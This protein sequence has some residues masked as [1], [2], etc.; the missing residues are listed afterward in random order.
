MQ[1]LTCP[2]CAG[3]FVSSEESAGRVV[4][5]PHCHAQIQD[6][7]FASS[8][9]P[10]E[11]S[12]E[13]GAPT[14]DPPVTLPLPSPSEEVGKTPQW[15]NIPEHD[16]LKFL[17]KGGMGIVLQA[18]HRV[19]DRLVAVKMP[20]AGDWMD[21][22]DRERFLREARAT[23]KLRHPNI[24]PVFEVGET[25][26]RPYITMAY[27]EGESL[28]QWAR[29][30]K[31]N[32]R[33]AAEMLA[34]L[35]RAVEFAHQQGIVHRDIKPQNVLVDR[36]SGQPMLMD[37]GLA[38]EM[39]LA[40][41]ELT[42]SGQV[43]GTPAYMAPEQAAGRLRDV[44]PRSDVYALGAVLYHLLCGRPP[45]L[46][47]GG[48]VLRQL[49]TDVPPA[50]RKLAP[51]TN[52]DLETICLT[53][54]ARE[55]LRRY[56]SAS[57]LAA[58]LQRFVIGEAI[59]AHREGLPR[60]ISRMVRRRPVV[61]ALTTLLMVTIA[62]FTYSA[63]VT[64][65]IA[66]LR[67]TIRNRVD[68]NDWTPSHFNQTESDID[69][70]ATM[71]PEQA[72]LDRE[73]FHQ[74]FAESLQAAIQQQRVP[75]EESTR[76]E[77]GIAAL[78][79]RD[80]SRAADLTE[81]LAARL[82]DW[83]LAF[84]LRPPF[85]NLGAIFDQEKVHIDGD[86]LRTT[87]GTVPTR[88]A[89]AGDASVEVEFQGDD[90]PTVPF[91]ILVD[92]DSRTKG[93][94]R[95][96]EFVVGPS[97]HA[98]EHKK[99][100]ELVVARNGAPLRREPLDPQAGS[101][102]FSVSRVA[103][104]LSVKLNDLPVIDFYDVVPL[105]Q[106]KSP[107]VAIEWPDT[108]GLTYL[109]A[110]GRPLSKS[111]SPL[112]SGDDKLSHGRFAGALAEYQAAAVASNQG[113]FDQEA[114]YKQ[115]LCLAKLNRLD[116]ARPLLERL[117]AEQGE[118]W[119]ALA[120]CQLW[121]GYLQS[122]KTNEAFGV[123]E[124][125]ST[126]YPSDFLRSLVSIELISSIVQKYHA[127][128]SGVA[129]F[130]FDAE[131]ER[132]LERAEKVQEFF[133]MTGVEHDMTI[134]WLYRSRMMMG[135]NQRAIELGQRLVRDAASL[136]ETGHSRWV[137]FIETYAWLLRLQE[138]PQRA[139]NEIQSQ[140]T[141]SRRKERIGLLVESAR[142][143]AALNQ[144]EQARQELDELRRAALAGTLEYRFHAQACLLRGFFAEA[145]GDA[146][147]AREAWLEG[148]PGKLPIYTWSR[149]T[150]IDD[151]AHA[152]LLATLTEQFAT[153]DLEVILDRVTGRLGKLFSLSMVKGFRNV[154]LMDMPPAT[155]AAIARQSCRR[156]GTRELVR[157]V[158]F[159]ELPI[160]EL[161]RK[162]LGEVVMQLTA[163]FVLDGQISA[164]QE[165]IC[166]EAGQ[167]LFTAY[168]TGKINN[169]QGLKVAM[170]WKG[171]TAGQGW[172]GVASAIGPELRG[173]LAYIFGLRHLR[174][175]NGK[176][177]AAKFFDEAL[178]CSQPDSVLRR[179]VQAE[180]DRHE[181]ER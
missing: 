167:D 82:G 65:R 78:A 165:A 13:T 27:I 155:I 18:R 180:L 178:A 161:L 24:C 174:M 71:V 162:A 97:T 100:L 157:Q 17:G 31:P 177:S 7:A 35:A 60:K 181:D 92:M 59:L 104:H 179:L 25:E 135:D 163:G 111:V 95:G 26:N 120:F 47:G 10:T 20:L 173:Q 19:L 14:Q 106:P 8:E 30:R 88:V 57:A 147:A 83:Q 126:R 128:A 77:A 58:D 172:A 144:W 39:A 146:G 76:I 51:N 46:G 102:R 12:V 119:P 123:F 48:E 122:G 115:A 37:F 90:V 33:E 94:V 41:S 53:A 96:Y 55:P 153:E 68:A 171:Q 40:D 49:Q 23:A 121:A 28:V 21:D 70:L 9:I 114:R 151:L 132:N 36:A 98:N 150:T 145:K 125:L 11:T 116:E 64:R 134:Y 158:A 4:A 85:A 42:Q 52:R 105:T 66:E 137:Q 74:R 107:V 5:C 91:G 44:G 6:S 175:K 149:L 1:S 130:F 143:H 54:M 56:E 168:Y 164:D 159:R 112:E 93:G 109:R 63:S 81:K 156:P 154:F 101:W 2:R 117:C 124:N 127:R 169:E 138:G 140:L 62:W 99:R 61:V 166:R 129:Q 22:A 32:G 89:C 79:T 86:V 160:N 75:K 113:D 69:R 3:A 141:E 142:S 67:G 170:T 131:R 110:S 139:L 45:Y 43:L 73:R 84:E 152:V 148:V 29:D 108:L 15:P 103:D 34:V 136:D 72:K 16:V 80:K 38:K 176:Q 118:R 87:A 50:P 133:G